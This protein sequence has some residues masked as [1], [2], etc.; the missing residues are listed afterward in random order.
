MVDKVRKYLMVLVLILM[1]ISYGCWG[2]GVNGP[3]Y[4]PNEKAAYSIWESSWKANIDGSI[5]YDKSTSGGVKVTGH[6]RTRI[7]EVPS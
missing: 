1:A 7:S 4:N 2:G 6:E 5:Y 3:E